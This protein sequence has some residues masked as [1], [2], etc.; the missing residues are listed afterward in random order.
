[1]YYDMTSLLHFTSLH[2]TFISGTLLCMNATMDPNLLKLVQQHVNALKTDV[3][4]LTFEVQEDRKRI[5]Q[6]LT[7][8]STSLE[9]LEATVVIVQRK[10][11]VMKEEKTL[12]SSKVDA[13]R[14]NVENL[15]LQKPK[16]KGAKPRAACAQEQLRLYSDLKPSMNLIDHD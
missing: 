4:Q 10:Q 1:M 11:E 9:Q 15:K 12:L 13:L 8:M 3:D 14:V 16:Q 5:S 7:E 6:A 2:F